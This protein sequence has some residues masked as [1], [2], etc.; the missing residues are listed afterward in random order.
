MGLALCSIPVSDI[1][2]SPAGPTGRTGSGTPPQAAAA[3]A[4]RGTLLLPSAP[5]LAVPLYSKVNIEC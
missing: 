1:L 4:I 2:L 3:A 5:L